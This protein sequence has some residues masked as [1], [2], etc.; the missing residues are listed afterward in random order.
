M[1][2]RTL[3]DDHE[4]MA[5]LEEKLAAAV[6]EGT[7]CSLTTQECLALLVHKV[8]NTSTWIALN[9]MEMSDL[10]TPIT[11]NISEQRLNKLLP[12]WRQRAMP[13]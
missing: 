11:N 6:S 4:R 8:M 9:G 2:A 1:S 5:A 3:M 10:V 7:G 13:T 12:D